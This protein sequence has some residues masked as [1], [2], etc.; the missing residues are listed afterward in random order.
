MLLWPSPQ[1]MPGMAMPGMIPGM[2]P[3]MMPGMTGMPGMA[4]VNP[5]QALLAR[6]NATMVGA[7]PGANPGLLQLQRMRMMQ[8][9]GM[10]M[11]G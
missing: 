10:P 9:M 2:M 4:A 7:T 1:A 11:T 8:Q 5:L 3:G 6:A